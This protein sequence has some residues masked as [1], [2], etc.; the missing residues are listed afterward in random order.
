[1]VYSS[2]FS[3]TRIKRKIIM[4][5]KSLSYT[6]K[7]FFR[8]LFTL[9][10]FL[11]LLSCR[12]HLPVQYYVVD[13]DKQILSE[14]TDA[15]QKKEFLKAEKLFRKMTEESYNKNVRQIALYGLACTKFALAENNDQ[16]NQ[17]FDVWYSWYKIPSEKLFV[18]DPRMMEPAFERII[19]H[20]W[21]IDTLSEK[22]LTDETEAL[23]KTGNPQNYE[24]NIVENPSQKE[25]DYEKLN[26]DKNKISINGIGASGS[27]TEIQYLLE[28]REKEI[29][30]LRQQLSSMEKNIKS[31]KNQIHAIEEIHQEIFE[32]KKGMR[33]R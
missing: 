11:H 12:G 10:L 24:M 29:L 7:M 28:S 5:Q 20:R 16:L 14:A 4:N 27:G 22:R 31:L 2:D 17:A 26:K 32:K 8:Y 9:A 3:T 1:L 23:I 6:V 30:K 13:E 19:S 18:E 15:F 21:I 33:L 25:F